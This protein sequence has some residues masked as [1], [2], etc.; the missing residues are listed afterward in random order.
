[1]TGDRETAFVNPLFGVWRN[2]PLGE[3]NYLGINKN[4]DGA[5]FS[6]ADEKD[7]QRLTNLGGG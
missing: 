1:M 3:L 2:F 4:C 7:A 5:V 6:G